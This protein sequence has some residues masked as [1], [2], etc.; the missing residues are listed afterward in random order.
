MFVKAGFSFMEINVYIKNPHII[1]SFIPYRESILHH[2]FSLFFF[3]VFF[4]LLLGLLETCIVCDL[5]KMFNYTV[6]IMSHIFLFVISINQVFCYKI[7][8]I[9]KVFLRK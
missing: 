4:Y 3:R 9:F 8:R 7:K 6:F 5:N 2:N 1:L